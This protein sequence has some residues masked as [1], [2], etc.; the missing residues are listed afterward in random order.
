MTKG[1]EKE[2]VWC[3]V[4]KNEADDI[5]GGMARA[6]KITEP[7][8]GFMYSIPV[9]S[10]LINVSSTVSSSGY[11]ANMDQII[12]ALD[13]LKGGKEWRTAAETES[14]ENRA[15]KT[16]FLENLVG[17]YCIV[18]R[19][20]YED[21]YDSVLDG[22]AT[23]RKHEFWHHGGFRIGRS[24]RGMGRSLYFRGSEQRRTAP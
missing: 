5:F 13:D 14:S 3:V 10:G 11:G 18:P 1:P 20:Y 16:T 9:R 21:V 15:L 22:A 4:E 7:G 24:E 19:D 8:R 2:F 17:L 23:W 12:S 6:G